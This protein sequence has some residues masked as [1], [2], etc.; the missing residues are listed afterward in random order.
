[1]KPV[2][3]AIS[4]ASFIGHYFKILLSKLKQFKTAKHVVLISMVLVCIVVR[5]V[6]LSFDKNQNKIQSVTQKYQKV[7]SRIPKFVP[8][9][10]VLQRNNFFKIR[11]VHFK[12]VQADVKYFLVNGRQ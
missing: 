2:E 12:E 11:Q 4:D 9:G 3:H 6:A 7:K 5:Y 10:T 1:M 8:S